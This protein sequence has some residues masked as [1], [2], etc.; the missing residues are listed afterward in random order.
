MPQ[1]PP[2]LKERGLIPIL[3]SPAEFPSWL[4]ES[5]P[6]PSST[7]QAGA[8]SWVK[9]VGRVPNQIPTSPAETPLPLMESEPN[10]SSSI[11]AE[12]LL[13]APAAFPLAE[14]QVMGPASM[15]SV[16]WAVDACMGDVSTS[17]QR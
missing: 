8:P 6:D 16:C 3:I 9:E 7:I 15:V 14:E 1:A 13:P 5:E 12:A 17:A 4:R 11:L 2:Q 10:P